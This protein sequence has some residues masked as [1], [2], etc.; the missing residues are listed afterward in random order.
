MIRSRE[1]GVGEDR[2]R[3]LSS[4]KASA[5][6]MTFAAVHGEAQD[7]RHHIGTPH[8]KFFGDLRRAVGRAVI[9]HDQLRFRPVGLQITQQSEQIF[10]QALRFVERRDDN[11]ELGRSHA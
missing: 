6:G 1:I 3:R 11:S 9:D 7:A 2:D 10:G 4:E 8:E 5:D